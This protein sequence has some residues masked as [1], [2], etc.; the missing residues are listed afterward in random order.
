MRDLSMMSN[1]EFDQTCRRVANNWRRLSPL[2]QFML[3]LAD[4]IPAIVMC[5]RLRQSEAWQCR[6]TCFS[7]GSGAR[8]CCEAAPGMA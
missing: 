3:G 5:L 6:P 2:R 7:S 8:T 1:A 4:E